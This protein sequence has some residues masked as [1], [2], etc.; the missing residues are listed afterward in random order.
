MTKTFMHDGLQATIQNISREGIQIRTKTAL[1]V[2]DALTIALALERGIVR[3][4]GTVVYLKSLADGHSLAGLR[5]LDLSAED[6]RVL[7]GFL[8]S[9]L[10]KGTLEKSER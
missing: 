1:A 4:G 5:F 6:A 3:F 10:P 2:G 8:K 9:R 7:D